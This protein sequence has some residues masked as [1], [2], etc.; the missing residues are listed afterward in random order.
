MC[1][2]LRETGIE[3]LLAT[4]NAGL[5]VEISESTVNHK[6]VPT[7]F[8][9]AQLGESFKFSR[10]MSVWLDENVGRFDVVHI[11][12][13]FNHACVS[14][15][16]ACR[17]LRVPYVIRP[18]GSLDPWS[19]KQKRFRKQVFWRVT[20]RVM[21]QAAAAVHYTTRA[22]QEA[23][24]SSLGLDN[25][26]VIPLGIEAEVVDSSINGSE[27]FREF[28]MLSG[29]PYV[30]VLSRL[31]PKKAVDVLIDAFLSV[32]EDSTFDDWRLAIAGEGPD[33]YV[34]LLRQK[35]IVEKAQ[36]RVIFTGWL[37]GSRKQQ[38]LKHSSL[39]ALTSF[40]ENFGV[41]VMEALS[42]SVPVIVSTHVNLANE[43]RKAKAGWIVD[44]QREAI[45]RTLRDAFLS[46]EERLL[47]G[48]AGKLFS[49]SYSWPAIARQLAS[50]YSSISP[51]K[52]ACLEVVA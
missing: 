20:G 32:V 19:M 21:M 33:D 42:Q 8:F 25:G 15:A 3:V 43:I 48:R 50:M 39:L 41:C 26:T 31:H 29:R 36:E 45:A 23:V 38:I 12:A 10:P 34:S 30:L 6:G 27:L 44:V 46:H 24:E 5:D 2:A 7:I 11:H 49:Q 17:R 47:R 52:H 16:T 18:L 28:P 22:E 35:I 1:R 9:P 37:E 51:A 40:Q 4:T 13:V 14:A